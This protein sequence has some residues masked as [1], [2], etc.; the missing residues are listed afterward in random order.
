MAGTGWMNAARARAEVPMTTIIDLRKAA[1]AAR[2]RELLAGLPDWFTVFGEWTPSPQRRVVTSTARLAL[3]VHCGHWWPLDPD[4]P[5][6]D[7]ELCPA[8]NGDE[9]A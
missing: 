5:A 3:C 9:P 2:L 8:N 6:G 4:E 7:C 1:L